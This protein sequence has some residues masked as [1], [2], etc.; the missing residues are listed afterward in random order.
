MSKETHKGIDHKRRRLLSTLLAAG[1][2]TIAGGRLR[3]GFSARAKSSQK[4]ELNS[5]GIAT[6]WLNS[7][8][9]TAAGMNGKVVL[10]DFWTYTCINWLRTLPYVRAWASKYGTRGLV[11]IGV[12]APEFEFEK[13]LD[14]VRRSVM[15][16]HVDYPVAIDNDHAIWRAFRNEYW[17]ALYFIDAQGRLRNHQFGEGKYEQAERMIQQ[18]LTEAGHSAAP[19]DL[20]SVDPRGA[21]VAADWSDLQS[22]ENYL[23]YERTE[24]FAS[25]GGAVPDK[26]HVYTTPKQLRL[27]QWALSGKWTSES[28]AASLNEA[29]GRIAYRFHARDLHLVMKSAI[30]DKSVRFRV[31]IDGEPPGPAHGVDIDDQGYGTLVE[32]RMYQVIRQSKPILDRQAE[33]EFLDPGAEAFSFTFG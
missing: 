29:N 16:M 23:G 18:L 3:G 11:V 10:I 31:L 17:P 28:H 12:H 19:H 32:A 1:A 13:D 7:P 22:A 27:N 5:L 15:A 14:N 4:G 33:I 9:L 21:E 20:V 6:Q 24:N 26:P 30:R 8:P 25:P 2:M